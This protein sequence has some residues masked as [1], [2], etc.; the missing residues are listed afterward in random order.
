MTVAIFSECGQYRWRLER[1]TGLPGDKTIVNCGYNPSTADAMKNDPTITRDIAFANREGVA[2]L[3]K[4]NM[5]GIISPF[6]TIISEVKNPVGLLNDD[7]IKQALDD[8]ANSK[9][10]YIFLATW[11]APKGL[12]K[13]QLEIFKEREAAILAL[14]EE[15]HC[16]GMTKTGHPKHPLYLRAD[17]PIIPYENQDTNKS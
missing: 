1:F 14:S 11:G 15:W 3:I 17:T 2:R 10:G 6:P 8:A 12:K 9:D 4:V 16:F 5:F 13:P 7:A